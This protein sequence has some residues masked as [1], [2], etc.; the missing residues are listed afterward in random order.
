MVVVLITIAAN[1]GAIPF[2]NISHTF[3]QH[4]AHLHKTDP[5]RTGNLPAS[6]PFTNSHFARHYCGGPIS[7]SSAF[8]AVPVTPPLAFTRLYSYESNRR[9]LG[10]RD[11]HL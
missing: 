1:S 9:R 7:T 6:I 10:R 8:M 11:M 5:S 3:P 4:P 2:P